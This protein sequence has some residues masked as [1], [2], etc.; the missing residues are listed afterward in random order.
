MGVP[1]LFGAIEGGVVKWRGLGDV[2]EN[3]RKAG[4][5]QQEPCKVILAFSPS[6][7][8]TETRCSTCAEMTSV[9]ATPTSANALSA[10]LRKLMVLSG[11][12]IG[13]LI[14]MCFFPAAAAI[15]PSASDNASALLSKLFGMLVE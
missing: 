8:P 4:I 7:I 2:R 14:F 6:L 1:R 3:P 10:P 15:D 5:G 9:Q 12:R 11:G 13:L